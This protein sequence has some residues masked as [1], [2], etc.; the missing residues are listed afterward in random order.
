MG[1]AQSLVVTAVVFHAF[2]E[3]QQPLERALANDHDLSEIR[4]EIR[5][6]FPHLEEERR[7]QRWGFVAGPASNTGPVAAIVE[8]RLD[9]GLPD[10]DL[11][12]DTI[13]GDLAALEAG[14]YA[15]PP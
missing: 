7:R 2:E 1:R 9:V 15:A 6:C 4:Q 12:P 5:R 3:G 13:T 11:P 10:H 8:P 14:I